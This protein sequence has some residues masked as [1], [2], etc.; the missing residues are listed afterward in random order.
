[1][2]PSISNVLVGLFLIWGAYALGANTSGGIVV[3]TVYDTLALGAY[4]TRVGELTL[5]RDGLKARLEGVREVQP[6]TV[7]VVDTL[8]TP[9]DTVLR[10]VN[11]DRRGR[12][13]VE[14][15]ARDPGSE[16]SFYRPSLA[17]GL[18]VSRCDEGWQIK[19][20]EVLCDPAKLGHL[21]LGLNVGSDIYAGAWW[22]PSYRSAWE[23]FAGRTEDRWVFG[24]RR[25][26]QVF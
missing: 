11:V 12:L 4:Q 17:T 21:W 2:R 6:D 22:R 25:G 8:V 1:M 14:T 13:A 7:F 26:W 18:D 10:F 23:V 24:A 15:Y 3:Q 5:E 9:P 20:G 19:D 16:G